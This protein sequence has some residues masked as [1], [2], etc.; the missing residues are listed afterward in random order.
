MSW[1]TR[2]PLHGYQRISQQKS[3]RPGESE[4]YIQN[5]EQKELP[6]WNTLEVKERYKDFP[7]KKLRE[8][9]TTRQEMQ[10]G[11]LP[12]EVKGRKLVTW[13]YKSPW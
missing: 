4:W 5:I 9:I 7:R 8:F 13:K 11:V 1:H 12:A 6:T 10:K 2:E 3:C